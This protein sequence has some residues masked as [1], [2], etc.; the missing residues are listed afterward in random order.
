[1]APSAPHKGGD[2]EKR[3]KP[4]PATSSLSIRGFFLTDVVNHVGQHGPD[5]LIAD[6]IE[7]L[8][9]APIRL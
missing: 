4:F 3:Q 7:N 8:P 9:P 1:M 5:M 6:H 2:A